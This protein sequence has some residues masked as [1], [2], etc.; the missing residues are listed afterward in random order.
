MAAEGSERARSVPFPDDMRIGD[1][2]L[3]PSIDRLSRNGTSVHLRPQLTNLLVLLAQ[4]AGRTVSKD[5]I[6]SKVWEG[7][8]VAESG[9]TRCIAEIR[10][11]LGDDARDP[12]IV[13]TIT[14][15][16]YRLMAPVERVEPPAAAEPAADRGRSAGAARRAEPPARSSAVAA[17]Q[18]LSARMRASRR[19]L[20]LRLRTHRRS[21]PRPWP[22]PASR[23][24]PLSAGDGRC[25]A[26][27][28]T[29][30]CGVVVLA[31]TWGAMKLTPRPVLSER[32][33]VL[34]ADVENTTGDPA[35]DQT[36]RLALGVQ[37]G[38][39]PFLRILP[40][41]RVRASLGLMARPHQRADRRR[42]GARVV[43]PG[44]RDG[45]AGRVDFEAGGSLRGWAR[46]RCLRGRRV[47]RPGI[48]RS[49]GQRRGARRRWERRRAA[50]GASW[51]SRAS[52]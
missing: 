41:A 3:Q 31:L 8:F 32:D 35:F 5:E 4:N 20:R 30:A 33:T 15:R 37:L 16:G 12:K 28:L 48:D 43:P 42:R 29:S 47:D 11:A 49:G 26:A 22:M 46:G 9:M 39:A 14:K 44:G 52:R 34:L 17:G 23:R 50:C 51:A 21:S 24:D 36:L 6:L 10:Q 1:W 27:V 25:R 2:L 7:Q 13:Q 40:D 18:P 19:R 45:A 38:Q